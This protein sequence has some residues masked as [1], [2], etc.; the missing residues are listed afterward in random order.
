MA[1]KKVSSNTLLKIIFE[2]YKNDPEGLL[3][4]LE[5]TV[6]S[7]ESLVDFAQSAVE[8]LEMDEEDE[9]AQKVEFDEDLEKVPA[10]L[11]T[12]LI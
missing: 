3:S 12:S 8:C 1:T 9:K 5:N 2:A 10:L 11:Q 7:E 6:D 4:D